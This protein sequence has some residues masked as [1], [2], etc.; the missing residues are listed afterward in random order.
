MSF[1]DSGL[2]N[3]I[4]RDITSLGSAEISG[5]IFL[6]LLSLGRNELALQ[7]LV[8][9]AICMA[10]IYVIRLLFFRARPGRVRQRY[11]T[12]FHRMDASSF[13]SIHAY[14][15][16]LIPV[17]LSQGLGFFSVA[18]LWVVGISI[19]LSRLYMKKHHPTDVLVG[20]VL[21]LLVSYAVIAVF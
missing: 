10:S 9:N 7:F 4:M 14:R 1:T 20:F 12:I 11:A 19:A 16:A 15:S 3:T 6:G 8:A 21:G 2:L 13:P 5:I 17:V 18:L